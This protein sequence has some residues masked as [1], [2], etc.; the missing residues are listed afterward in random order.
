MMKLPSAAKIRISEWYRS[1]GEQERKLEQ[2]RTENATR[3][4]CVFTSFDSG[5]FNAEELLKHSH[6][7]FMAQLQA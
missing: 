7:L 3:M 2:G 4:K 6:P 5:F 1:H